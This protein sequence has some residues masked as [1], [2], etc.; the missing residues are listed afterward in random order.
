MG[1]TTWVVVTAAVVAVVFSAG[2]IVV[3]D[4]EPAVSV[5][6]NAA[7]V[8]F[9]AFATVCAGR[10]AR[11]TAGRKRLVWLSICIGLG[12]W[13]V[14]SFLWA[15]FELVTDIPPFP[16]VADLGYLVFPIGACIGLA[17][18]PVGHPGQSRTRLVLDGLIAAA[19]LFQISWV[20]VLRDTYE[21]DD[22]SRFA[23]GLSLAYPVCD[24]VVITVAV[25]AQ[26]RARAGQRR[27]LTFLTLGV[28]VMAL[29]DSAFVYL[30]AAGTYEDEI[31]RVVD[32]GYLVGLLVIAVAALLAVDEPATEPSLVRVPSRLALWLPYVPVAVAAAVCT[33][34]N[35]HESGMAPLFLSTLVL[36]TAVLLRQFFVVRENRRL[37]DLVAEQALRDPLTGLANR[38]L[39]NDR[40]SHAMQLHVRDRQPVAVLSLDLDDFKLVNDN[41][42]HP[43]G[44]QLLVLAAQRILG[45]VRA[46]DTV[47]RV[48]GDEF[49]VLL[50]GKTEHS[51]QVAR[52]LMASF[53][54]QFVIDGHDLLLRPSIGLAVATGDD[55][56][57][58]A[59]ALLKHAD[60]A[61]Y[62]AK[63]SRT[64]GVHTFDPEMTRT[65]P[66]GTGKVGNAGTSTVRLLGQLRNTI[67]HAGL[68]LVYQPKFGLRDGEFVGVEA[69]VRWP[70]PERGLLGPDK[71]LPL[72]RE[73]G[74]MR[75]LTDLVVERALE[76]VARWKANGV[77]VPVAVNMFAPSLCDLEL[78]KR[79]LRSLDERD[80]SP[81]L[82]T[83]EIT[84]DLLLDDVDRTRQVLDSL[85]G[86]GTRVAI[87]D[88]GSGYSALGYLCELPIDEVKLDRQFI[89]P[90]VDDARAAAVVRAVVD[91]AHELGMTVV[92]EGVE[93]DDTTTMLRDYGC[94]VAQGFHFSPPLAGAELCD[95]LRRLTSPEPASSRSS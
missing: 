44:D 23:F 78:P 85:R 16:S 93:N 5:M 31:G 9:A 27:T 83:I 30:T 89:A 77:R 41:L 67:D 29:S 69:L 38:A 13:L 80:L 72:V 75:S 81:D 14:G 25:L 86:R 11:S 3:G 18:Y 56:T 82:L 60:L 84:E 55:A 92:A 10:A 94:D 19:A 48:G 24:L 90:I 6:T 62:S 49:A 58:S 43:A 40:L 71:F 63:R 22:T 45:C 7:S 28:V 34:T 73:Y 59:E 57:V 26:T 54:E 39:F 2:F 33:P 79:I 68:S 20:M 52:R 36:V 17:L 91:L 64:G 35:L 15:Y 47:A 32:V 4:D 74:L 46:G 12:G 42:G 95:L 50:E 61:M 76:D 8:L 1:K 66:K 87:D 70:H 65:R 51:R 21:A 37:L 53:D 88:F